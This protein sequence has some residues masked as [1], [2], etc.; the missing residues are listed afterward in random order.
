M[1]R[2]I[3]NFFILAFF[4]DAG[5]SVVDEFVSF[6]FEIQSLNKIRNFTAYFVILFS[7]P[8]F[9]IVGLDA[10]LPK[11]VLFPLILFVFWSVF[12]AYPLSLFLN[13]R[14]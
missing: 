6:Y 9:L 2:A 7:L 11:L 13:G 1:I 5:L 10:R 3:T 12:A 4:F 8:M 14:P